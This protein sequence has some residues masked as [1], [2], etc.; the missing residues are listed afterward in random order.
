MLMREYCS[1]ISDKSIMK[2]V[3]D[4]WDKTHLVIFNT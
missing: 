3:F 4:I 2:V 1:L